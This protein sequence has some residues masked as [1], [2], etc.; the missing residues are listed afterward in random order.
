MEEEKRQKYVEQMKK[1]K[2]DHIALNSEKTRL[3]L[4]DAKEA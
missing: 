1:V 2:M 3:L 4:G